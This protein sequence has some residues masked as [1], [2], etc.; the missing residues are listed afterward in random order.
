[1]S[2]PRPTRR[3]LFGTKRGGTNS[4]SLHGA[5]DDPDRP[6][7]QVRP[8]SLGG[9]CGWREA[10]DVVGPLTDDLCTA[11]CVRW[12]TEDAELLVTHLVAVAVHAGCHEQTPRGDPLAVREQNP[13]PGPAAL[14][15]LSD[16][17]VEDL[18]LV[19][20]HLVPPDARSSPGASRHATRTR[21]CAPRGRCTASPSPPRE[22]CGG[23]GTTPAPPTVLRHRRQPPRR[24][25][26]S[27][28]RGWP[29][30]SSNDNKRCC[31]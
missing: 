8:L 13:E 7:H 9:G 14:H 17:A 22:P 27:C 5:L 4:A 19:G 30:R 28:P 15:K 31:F 29:R 3:L 11:D 24:R 18:A 25:N 20:L 2:Q 21:A 26:R 12:T 6:G 23:P 10:H 1:M 16:G